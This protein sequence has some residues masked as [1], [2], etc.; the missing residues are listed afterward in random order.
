M[1][2]EA[3]WIL[4]AARD[5]NPNNGW[6]NSNS[7]YAMHEVCQK[8]KNVYDVCDIAGN[9]MEWVNDWKTSFKDSVVTNFI[10][11]FSGGSLNECVVKGGSF[12]NSPDVTKIHNRGDIYI[13]TVST[14][15]DYVGGRLAFGPI[16][17]ATWMSDG[18]TSFSQAYSVATAASIKARLGTTRAKLAFRNGESGNLAVLNYA[19]G[20]SE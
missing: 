1:L 4:V 9:A 7:D 6:N 13:V 5:W 15:A 20:T 11:S 3:E 8:S 2:T 14:K 12:R 18:K 10:G 19:N 17:N 16:P